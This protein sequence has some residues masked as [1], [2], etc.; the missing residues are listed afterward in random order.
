M[1]KPIRAW[2]P[3]AISSGSKKKSSWFS[4]PQRTELQFKKKGDGGS[5]AAWH[6]VEGEHCVCGCACCVRDFVAD[7]Y[8]NAEA[9][10]LE[11]FAF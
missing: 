11:Y 1:K 3:V 4:L 10:V 5:L 7:H 2:A 8:V 6:Y 9:R